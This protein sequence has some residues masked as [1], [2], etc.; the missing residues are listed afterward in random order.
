MMVQQTCEQLGEPRPVRWFQSNH[1]MDIVEELHSKLLGPAAWVPA[2][3]STREAWSPVKA[4]SAH[5]T[6]TSHTQATFNVCTRADTICIRMSQATHVTS[7]VCH[8][9][10]HKPHTGDF[11][12][13]HSCRS[14]M[15]MHV[16]G[17]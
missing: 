6:C 11:E 15:H 13:V 3:D 7:H 14:H 10:W 4:A 16:T 8:I 1:V 12:R 17:T 9:P 2:L 5:Q